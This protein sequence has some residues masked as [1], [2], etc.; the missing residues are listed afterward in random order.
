[1]SDSNDKLAIDG[2]PKTREKPWPARHLFGQEEKQAAI[3]L[4]DKAIAS[5]N[6]FGYNGP[7]EEAYCQEFAQT[8]GGGYA[9]G[10]NSGS[11]AV[12]VALR[13]LDLEPF[14]EVIVPP[15][16]DPGGF[17]PV[18]LMNCIPVPADAAPG[19]YNT[20]AEQIAARITPRTSAILIAHI[21]GIPVDMDPVLELAKSKGLPVVEDCAQAHGATYKGKPVGTLGTVAAFS[22]MFGK[23]HATGGQ[24]GVVFSRDEKIYWA[25]RRA[26]DRGKPFGI[27]GAAG[28]VL[29]SINLNSNDLNAAIGRVQLKKLPRIVE[30][31]RKFA[32]A[33]AQGCQ[34]T[35]STR[36]LTGPAD[37]APS[38]WFLIFQFNGDAIGV[39]KDQ[40]AKALE[41]EGLP[42]RPTYSN[43]MTAAPW[44][45]QRRVFGT[46]RLPWSSPQYKGNPDQEYP[47]PNTLATD[48]S[49]FN[50]FI[51]ENCGEQEAAD[52]V[53]AIK[54]VEK[55]YA[56]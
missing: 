42:F 45:K 48:A 4:F 53:R 43:T 1:M 12:Y 17:M 20:A 40:F 10:V 34:S 25:A 30:N 21:A 18:P 29:A 6:A 37:S 26:A 5:G 44:Y 15:I 38:Y 32:A 8:L 16:S 54:K 36:L 51:H 28:N 50:L 11:S 49:C 19:S 46:S 52:V 55:A 33:V 9:D 47:L 14:T 56:K 7:D 3:D 35:R 23:H 22:T 13:S 24:G 27:E 31:R 2:G 39:S 41:A